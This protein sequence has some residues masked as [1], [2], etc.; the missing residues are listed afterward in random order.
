MMQKTEVGFKYAKKLRA[1][2]KRDNLNVITFN[3]IRALA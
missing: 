2:S 3:V 1:S